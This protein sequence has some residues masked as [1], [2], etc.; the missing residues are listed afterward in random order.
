M[1]NLKL[2]ANLFPISMPAIILT[3]ASVFSPFS[4]FAQLTETIWMCTGGNAMASNA[5]N[6]VVYDSGGPDGYYNDG[7][8]CTLLID[9][10]CAVS[11]TFMVQD[12]FTESCCDHLVV[13]DGDSESAP[14]L[15]NMYGQSA[16]QTVT[17]TS[18]KL[19]VRW[20]SDGSVIYPGFR[21][22]WT[23]ILVPPAAPVVNFTLSDAN[24]A[25]QKPVQ[26][27]ATSTNYPKQWQWDFGDNATSTEQNPTHAYSMP[28][29]Y[30]ARL[31]VTNCHNLSDTTE[32]TLQVQQAPSATIDPTSLELTANCGDTAQATLTL[33]NTGQGDLLYSAVGNGSFGG[34]VKV[35]VYT[36]YASYYSVINIRDI[37]NSYGPN[38]DV[39]FSSATDSMTLAA[40]LADRDILIFAD[41]P[42]SF[43]SWVVLNAQ[44][45]AIL[46]FVDSG[47]SLVF[48]GQQY[49]GN[50]MSLTGLWSSDFSGYDFSYSNI[51]F[52]VP[53]PITAGIPA[54]Y[55][56]QYATIGLKF[57]NP[58]YVSLST[59][60]GYSL[61][62]YRTEGSAKVVYFGSNFVN[63]DGILRQ[64]L[65]NTLQWC[66]TRSHIAI[67]PNE[68]QLAPGESVDL[69]VYFPT[70]EL[71]AGDYSGSVVISTNDPAQPSIDVPFTLHVLGAAVLE[72]TP[73]ALDFGD[74]MQFREQSQVVRIDNPGCETLDIQTITPSLAG[75]T[76]EP[77]QLSVPPFSTDSFTVTFAPLD[78]GQYNGNLTLTSNIGTNTLPLKGYATGAPV[79][80]INPTSLEAT[81]A[82]GDSVTLPVTVT[83]TGLGDLEIAADGVI[84]SAGLEPLKILILS[85]GTYDSYIAML[86]S[87]TIAARFPDA[88][89]TNF[90]DQQQINQL[91]G[92]LADKQLVVIP[93]VGF[94][95][96]SYYLQLGQVIRPFVE[97]GGGVIFTGTHAYQSLNAYNLLETSG[98]FNIYYAPPLDAVLPQ[99]PIMNG[100]DMQNTIY[101]EVFGHRFLSA[102]YESLVNMYQYSAVGVRQ[103][104][105][106]KVAYLGFRYVYP[107]YNTSKVM[108]NAVNW[109]AR[110]TWTSVNP[111]VLTV[112]PGES[113]TLYITLGA[114]SLVESSYQSTINWTTN[115]PLTPEISIAC[116][117]H[118]EGEPLLESSLP[119]L[120]FGVIQQ[121][122]QK[123]LE[124]PIKNTGCDTLN[125]TEVS[126][127]NIVF[128]IG[129]YPDI[130]LP[131]QAGVVKVK[132]APQL[133]G[134]Q[135]GTLTIETDGGTATVQ[136]VGNAVGAPVM[137]ISPASLE[138]QLSC[139]E[140]TTLP[141]TLN[142]TGLGGFSYQIGGL[143]A[144]R[145]VV[146]LT[147]GATGYRWDNLRSNILQNIPN[148][149]L[150]T[151]SGNDASAL[152]DSLN[153]NADILI[154]PPMEYLSDQVTYYAFAPV[155][156]DFLENGGQVLTFGGY[157]VQPL[158][159]MGLFSNFSVEQ[160]YSPN[161]RVINK[162]HPLTQFVPAEYQST[163][164]CYFGYFAPNDITALMKG[165]DNSQTFLGHRKEGLGN[166]VFWGQVFDY[167]DLTAIQ[168]L[169][170]IFSWFANPVPVGVSV[171]NAGGNIPSGGSQTI[172][173][174]FNGQGLPGG[175]YQGQIH[176]MGNDPVNNPLVIPVTMNVSFQPCADFTFQVPQCSGTVS[177]SDN[178]VNALTSWYW[179]FGDGGSAFVKN[180]THIYTSGGSF[181]VTLVG[182][183]NFGCDTISKIVEVNAPSGPVAINCQPQ[184]TSYCCEIGIT[185]VQIGTLN[186]F[187][188][189]ASEGY[190]D[191]SCTEGTELMAGNQ[192]PVKVVTS[193]QTWEY[194][195]MWID[196]NNNGSFGSN[197]LVFTDQA[198][199]DHQGFVTIPL[200]TVKNMPLRM[201]VLSEPTWNNPPSSPC[202]N[203]IN[204]QAEDYFVII[205]TM[206]GTTEP[207]NSLQ[208]RIYPNP[209]AGETWLEFT[210]NDAAPVELKIADQT[211]RIVWQ[212]LIDNPL[213]GT[214][215]IQLPE[216]PAG[217]FSVTVQSGTAVAVQ[218]LV[219]VDRP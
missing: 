210:L 203:L 120:N 111:A 56:A 143:N 29:T 82:C 205:K 191:Y 213:L 84:A 93:F 133:P 13:F 201:R 2:L 45:A 79:V 198:Y 187:S 171:L 90:T 28:G 212:N 151:Y 150:S 74:L 196:Y 83:N 193:T 10:G 142:N 27:T 101:D 68:G 109:C 199:I 177:F 78:T 104:G 192:Y 138:V 53:H 119:N 92:I 96:I 208:T 38:Y 100:V 121:F 55:Y 163:D 11:L 145:R 135:N 8:Y 159:Q 202:N 218:K 211:G 216:L 20:Y 172:Q 181:N 61:F 95:D 49:G 69:T 209:S 3:A 204:G 7:Q 214:N 217:A 67:Q 40:Q 24:P 105:L 30:T 156:Q 182:C 41:I 48:C 115:D 166:L 169:E 77:A 98:D 188:G 207:A 81:V 185:Q 200:T 1:C 52:D 175:Q 12:Y 124:V 80:G 149:A 167:Y 99:H 102:D 168:I 64:L 165:P 25:L 190:Q 148:V 106:G 19:F 219:R 125:V 94:Y 33:T 103:V 23:S 63:Y 37:M 147:L 51:P 88:E 126:T 60:N 17:S 215:T 18:S 71:I 153:N 72:A 195:R 118:V 47:G 146:A 85:A 206:I 57:T 131:G 161:I 174:E 140:T 59:V 137:S 6:G 123:T 179:D 170:N 75:Y 160:Y 36:T 155:V 15:L 22:V 194:V 16:P 14:V 154:I 112:P 116:T 43:D 35:L 184:T 117:L 186:Y 76:V 97:A 132:F 108:E 107:H 136:L 144:P 4:L 66:G 86:V 91:P 152:A 158:V 189:N 58:D 46:E 26:F 139:D 62:G 21:A 197:E 34:K 32:Q 50:V 180:P 89:I 44:R 54:I 113:A 178:T 176:L 65:D 73:G 129:T 122:A 31:I 130:L 157:Y 183:N 173:V 9:P 128:T 39:V 42:P 87:Q 70:D 114:Q 164:Y 5:P 110:P 127:N 141:I 134:G 162:T